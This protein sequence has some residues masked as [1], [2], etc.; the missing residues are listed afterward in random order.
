MENQTFGKLGSSRYI[1][2]TS[3]IRQSGQSLLAIISDV[4]DMSNLDAGQV[5]LQKSKV[6]L[7]EC[8]GEAVSSIKAD[9]ASKNIQFEAPVVSDIEIRADKDIIVKVLAKILHNAVK[10]TP[11]YGHVWVRT[12]FREGGVEIIVQDTGV[13]ISP[14]N[15]ERVTCP[16]E[17]IN[18]P[19][20]NGMKGSGLGLAIAQC[21]VRLHGGVLDVSSELGKGTQVRVK[22][23]AGDAPCGAR[24][25]P[26]D[27]SLSDRRIVA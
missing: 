24:I 9:A 7:Q 21:F 11:E 2:Y 6:S 4:L 23:P 1:E 5:Q 20:E 13:G 10:F 25:E 18:S 16:F 15:L 22:L 27:G 14:E 3:F 17:Q 8:I 12:N 26:A 19:I